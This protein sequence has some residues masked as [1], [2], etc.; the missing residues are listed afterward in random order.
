MARCTDRAASGWRG[1]AAG[2]RWAWASK[3]ELTRDPGCGP[4]PLV[5]SGKSLNS[6]E[7]QCHTYNTEL[8]LIIVPSQRLREDQRNSCKLSV[9]NKC[10]Q[11]GNLQKH[12]S[13][14]KYNFVVATSGNRNTEITSHSFCLLSPETSSLFCASVPSGPSASPPPLICRICL[15]SDP[16]LQV[17]CHCLVSMTVSWL[18]YHHGHPAVLP[19]SS[20]TPHLSVCSLQSSQ[21][22]FKNLNPVM[23]LLGSKP[24][25]SQT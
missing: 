22:H 1:S 12:T 10:V 19:A 24:F 6:S 23:C 2:W 9:L 21:L 7:P 15:T 17:H 18:S 13:I 8:D 4:G 20:P 3:S 16:D 11:I 14:E 5:A 25:S